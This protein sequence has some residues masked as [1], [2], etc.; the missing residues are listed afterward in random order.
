MGRA[1]DWNLIEDGYRGFEKLA[2]CYVEKEF[3]NSTWEKTGETRDGNK[4]ATA[5]IMGYQSDKFKK[6]QWWME[7]KYSHTSKILDRYRLDA[8]IVSAILEGDV[9]RVIFVTNILIR[10]RV[11]HDISAALKLSL[12][13]KEVFFCT[14]Y[15]LEYWL[16]QN[17]DVYKDFFKDP[18]APNIED[19]K[20]S[21][22]F[23]CQ[24][25]NFYNNECNRFTF[26]ESLREL[27]KNNK[28]V[29]EFCVFSAEAKTVVLKPEKNI[30]GVKILSGSKINLKAGVNEV[31][32]IF[33]ISKGYGYKS[34]SSQ[35]SLTFTIGNISIAPTYFI[36]PINEYPEHI[37]LP[38]QE[39]I[40]T[41][42]RTCINNFKTTSSC[43]YHFI[44][45]E[46]G[47]G[48]SHI[49]K[50]IIGF[51][52]I[53]DEIV[54]Y[55]ELTGMAKID[56]KIMISIVLF[57]LFPFLSY[58]QI[59][60]DYLKSIKNGIVSNNLIDLI[61]ICGNIE[62]TLDFFDKYNENYS[63]FYMKPAINRR[64]IILD[65][66]QK[67]GKQ[68]LNFLISLLIEIRMA[69]LPIFFVMSA[70]PYFFEKDSYSFL[71]EKCSVEKYHCKIDKD[72]IIS[73]LKNKNYNIDS[74]IASS[75]FS[76]TIELFIFAKYLVDKENPIK[77]ISD[78]VLTYKIFQRSNIMEEHI[79]NKFKNLFLNYPECKPLCNKIYWRS[80]PIELPKFSDEHNIA[81]HI[82]NAD[83][84]VY[85]AEDCLVPKH[86]IY[87][88]Y[89]CKHFKLKEEEIRT[90]YNKEEYLKY[91]FNI[92]TRNSI[93]NE[94]VNKIIDILNQKKY[95]TVIYILESIF[96]TDKKIE[97]KRRISEVNYYKLYMSYAY[98]SNQQSNMSNCLKMFD[99]IYNCTKNSANNELKIISLKVTWEL[100]VI[101]FENIEVENTKKLIRQMIC[102]IIQLQKSGILDKSIFKCINFFDGLVID[103]L[104][105]TLVNDKNA[106]KLYEFRKC[107]IKKHNYIYRYHSFN[108]RYALTLCTVNMLKCIN[109]LSQERGYFLR[110]HGNMDKHYLWCEF[111]LN[112]YK[113]IYYKNNKFMILALKAHNDMRI[114]QYANYRKKLP[115][116][117]SYYYMQGDI[118]NG[119]KYLLKESMFRRNMS[120]RM[121]AFYYISASLNDSL[122]KN[123]D[124]A[125][126]ALKQSCDLL[127]DLP[128]YKKLALHNYNLIKKN[129]FFENKIAFWFGEKLNENTFYIDPRSAW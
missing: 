84:A 96:E 39:K 51:N 63:F 85:N 29:G 45:G 118:A 65:D 80:E 125:L 72:D 88:Y 33:E 26:N 11:M 13:C 3:K 52:E 58:E 60:A 116:I 15:Q 81:R 73:Y 20:L 31:R 97:L 70:H 114:D 68:A 126:D 44:K 76:N 87:K 66:I 4:D 25:L 123:T 8:T 23:V 19:I 111:Y 47:V 35:Q 122:N 49:I 78:F 93:I 56:N 59:D 128:T 67:L 98:A 46:S 104:L 37:P 119:N 117:A 129:C 90:I 71:I 2:L 100:V 101:A 120:K 6:N 107:L 77:S 7:A 38:S 27:R 10:T 82:I 127:Q 121:R 14:R 109:I 62:K 53:S 42:I 89:Y 112:F 41:K 28:Y 99:D 17:S 43:S 103:T 40:I 94:C 64:I 83:L 75:F 12:K 24:N 106:D 30:K 36:N 57:I 105:Y 16:S 110:N 69:G 113:A 34:S 48:K 54:F 21:D 32:F 79:F 91:I 22:F 115:A 108:A 9:S 18:L 124:R 50:Q 61:S 5:I 86:D 74:N 55:A 1:I 95:H 102:T 92:E